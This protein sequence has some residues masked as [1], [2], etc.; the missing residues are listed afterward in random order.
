MDGL[1][2]GFFL[3]SRFS[4][5]QDRKIIEG[6]ATGIIQGTLPYFRGGGDVH[7]RIAL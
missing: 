4:M 2:Q 7:K 5:D 6:Q 1:C 3:G